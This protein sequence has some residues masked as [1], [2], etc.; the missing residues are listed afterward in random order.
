MYVK[1]PKG[2][3]EIIA[4]IKE[5]NRKIVM[6]N[7]AKAN[8]LNS[9]YASVFCRERN[10]WEIKLA[11]WGET[12]IINTRYIRKILAKIWRNKSV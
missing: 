10:I 8:I 11:N 3:R 2:Y 5:Q 4:A 6:D 7:I 1:R 9:Y 12:F